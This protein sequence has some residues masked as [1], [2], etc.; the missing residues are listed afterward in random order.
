MKS[1]GILTVVSGFS[2]AG[3]GTLLK[4]LLEKYEYSL[5]ISATTRAPREGEQNGREYFFLTTDEFERMIENN[6]LIEWAKYVD[7]YYGTPKSYVQE[8]LRQG[9]NVILEIEIQGALHI[10]KQFPE[11]LLLFVAPPTAQ[12]LKTRL[13]SRGTEDSNTI[14]KRLHRAGEESVFMEQ[15]DRIVINDNLEECVEELHTIIQKEQARVQAGA[16][17]TKRKAEQTAFI[18]KMKQELEEFQ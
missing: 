14:A 1:Q 9:K 13:V 7:N 5:S 16:A 18:H 15:Y 6:D 11:A 8:Q 17:A 12:D 2:G 4:A 3:K 10:R